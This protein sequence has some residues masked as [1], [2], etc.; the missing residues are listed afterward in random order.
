MLL[1]CEDLIQ[2]LTNM[3]T[4]F[5]AGGDMCAARYDLRSGRKIHAFSGHSDSIWALHYN[6]L[7]HRLVTGTRKPQ[8]TG[9]K[10]LQILE[11]RVVFVVL[12]YGKPARQLAP[13]AR[14][15]SGTI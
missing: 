2:L 7:T 14:S 10:V 8:I 1:V 9:T 5:V 4:V 12:K 6:S 15:E 13:I 11:I 3:R